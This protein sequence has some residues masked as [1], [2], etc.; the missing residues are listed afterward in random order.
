ML[1]QIVQG[2]R[3]G[4]HPFANFLKRSTDIIH[5]FH[6]RQISG[7]DFF[8]ALRA[9]DRVDAVIDRHDQRDRPEDTVVSHGRTV[10][11][12]IVIAGTGDLLTANECEVPCVLQGEAQFPYEGRDDYLIILQKRQS[13]N[14]GGC[15][16]CAVPHFLRGIFCDTKRDGRFVKIQTRHCF[17][18][19]IGYRVHR[20]LAG[21]WIHAADGRVLI[22]RADTRGLGR[23]SEAAEIEGVEFQ[24]EAIHIFLRLIQGDASCF[25]VCFQ[26]RPGVLVEPSDAGNARIVLRFQKNVVH[27]CHLA[28]LPEGTRRFGCDPIE[29]FCVALVLC[30]PGRIRG[31]C[32]HFP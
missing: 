17:K 15:S 5:G 22:G 19:H 10:R 29:A 7:P 25:Q 2:C 23:L 30:L 28:G 20:I 21:D 11:S 27:H 3:P 16:H 31:L 8:R 18:N 12:R 32:C 14:A 26:E 1:R 24:E 9:I 13:A 4:Q 6:I